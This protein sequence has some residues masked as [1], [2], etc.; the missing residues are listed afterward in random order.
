MT[1]T[2]P[3]RFRLAVSVL[4][5]AALALVG[6]C[7]FDPSADKKRTTIVL[8][9]Q[10]G[11]INPADRSIY[12]QSL[13]GIGKDLSGGDRLIVAP[14]NA[15]S[16]SQFIAAL[17]VSV[18]EVGIRLQDEAYLERAQT[19][20]AEALPLILPETPTSGANMTRLV[21]TIAAA[22]QAFGTQPKAG[23][24]LILLTDGVED[25]PIVKLD[26]IG[27]DREAAQVAL[28][29]ARSLGMLPNLAGIELSV[30]GAG[31]QDFAAVEDFW[32]AYASTT[33]ATVVQYGRLPFKAGG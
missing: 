14:V 29:K 30:V 28:S 33:G 26:R 11:S 25:S 13:E 27:G 20:V 1:Y 9:D 15:A 4:G 23:D 6:G 18:T 10:S 21:E 24:R 16:R 7:K 3:L 22:T 17:D 32:K 19:S 5:V 8:I 31:G 12:L 2:A